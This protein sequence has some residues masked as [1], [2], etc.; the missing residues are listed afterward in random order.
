MNNH[1]RNFSDII[2]KLKEMEIKLVK[3]F[4]N[5]I[6]MILLYFIYYINISYENFRII[7]E[8]QEELP[9][10]KILKVRLLKEVK[11]RKR[12]KI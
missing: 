6:S 1:I 3:E 12:Y 11:V 4:I 2:E 5:N 8:V 10:L 9:T 7:I